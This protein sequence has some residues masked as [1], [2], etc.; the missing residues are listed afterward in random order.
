VHSFFLLE[1][2]ALKASRVRRQEST[3][4]STDT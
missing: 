2:F 1:A 3:T 4:T